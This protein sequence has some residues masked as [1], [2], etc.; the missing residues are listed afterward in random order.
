[1]EKKEKQK[2]YN[3]NSQQEQ[4][5]IF[6]K[7][8]ENIS[9]NGPEK[10]INSNRNS[11]SFL[12]SF[13]NNRPYKN[14]FNIN[15]KNTADFEIFFEKRNSLFSSSKNSKKSKRFKFYN[16]YSEISTKTSNNLLRKIENYSFDYKIKQNNLNKKIDLT[17]SGLKTSFSRN[18]IL[19]SEIKSKLSNQDN[20]IINLLRKEENSK[21]I[22]DFIFTQKRK[23]RKQKQIKVNQFYNYFYNK[24]EINNNK[25]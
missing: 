2:K 10:E 11:F 1:M 21:N 4:K 13:T 20:L 23:K 25:I 8:L 5:K 18:Y 22:V 24:N 12:S 3:L 15:K 7:I 17:S 19:K 16:K 6:K 14:I 9:K